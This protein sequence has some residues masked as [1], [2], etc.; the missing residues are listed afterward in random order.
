MILGGGPVGLLTALLTG[1]EQINIKVFEKKTITELIATKRS[2]ALSLSTVGVL[3]KVGIDAEI[4][5][6]FI[7]IKKIHTSQ[8]N[9]FG[10]AVIGNEGSI[11]VGYVVNYGILSK[12]LLDQIKAKKNILFF[13]N[14]NIN[15]VDTKKQELILTNK[16]KINY[17]FLIIS[18]GGEN[19]LNSEFRYDENK[20]FEN[21][22]G[23]VSD[24][25]TEYKH[26]NCAYER[27][28]KTGPMAL[29]PIDNKSQSALIWTG[30]KSYIELL[31]KLN[32]IEFK[33]QIEKEFGERL[34]DVLSVG[35]K[36]IFPLKQKKLIK[37]YD[38]NLLVF[39]N[40]SHVLH[41]VAGQGFNLSVR[42]IDTFQK[43]AKE[44]NYV[45]D[46]SFLRKYSSMREIEIN[47]VMKFTKNILN[48]FENNILGVSKLRS[49]GLFSLDNA[50]I[51]KSIFT[52]KMSY[53]KNE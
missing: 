28:L 53:G 23:I 18:D 7:P 31:L 39:G 14:K 11:P 20:D 21:L 6:N 41:P 40:A 46:L 17:K 25:C 4:N 1:Q 33:K 35:K 15:K 10:R 50:S 51:L 24:I 32:D 36:H 22:F 37:F 47:R 29:L 42:D 27:F 12:L 8:K 9:S 38:K 19:F 45:L 34:G 16:E 48:L 30:E 3:K 43:L 2:L 5:N 49:F 26:N 44:K 52:Y 13:H